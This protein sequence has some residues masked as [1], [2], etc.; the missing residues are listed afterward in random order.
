[1]SVHQQY[2]LLSGERKV[3]KTQ[4]SC[5]SIVY[6]QPNATVIRN[7]LLEAGGDSSKHFLLQYLSK[8]L[9]QIEFTEELLTTWMDIVFNDDHY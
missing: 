9:C 1:M 7:A 4:K 6:L 2:K 3:E 8:R 5:N